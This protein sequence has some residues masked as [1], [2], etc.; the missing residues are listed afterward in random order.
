MKRKIT[1]APDEYYHIYSRGVD[2]RKI[3]LDKGD[4]YR[5]FALLFICNSTNSIKIRDQFRQGRS[6]A[7]VMLVKRNETLVDIGAYCLMPNHYHLL[8]RE[9]NDNGISTFMKK[10][11]TAYVMYFNKKNKRS[12]VLFQGRFGAE[13][14]NKDEYLKYIFA[15]IHLNPVKLIEPKWKDNGIKNF[16]KVKKFLNNYFWSS[17]LSY[18]MEQKNSILNKKEF[19]EYFKNKKEFKNFIDDWLKYQKE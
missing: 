2:K 8:I 4:Y 19:P 13:W 12:G 6:L 1:F 5:F 7:E 9:K 3:F 18:T 11:N 17:Y 10:L 16:A 14:L 15:Y